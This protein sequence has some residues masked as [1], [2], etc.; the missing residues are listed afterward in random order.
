MVN[1][2]ELFAY[3]FIGN[4]EMKLVP[5]PA[6][7]SDVWLLREGDLLFARRSLTIQGAGKC[8]LIRDMTRP[9]TFESSIIRVR[10]NPDLADPTF[11]YYFFRSP[12]GR[13]AIRS[14]TEQVAVAGIRSSDLRELTLHVPLVEEQ[15]RIADV[16]ARLDRL[17]DTDHRLMRQLAEAADAVWRGAVSTTTQTKPFGG[18]ATLSAQR[19][20]PSEVAADTSYLGLEHFAEDGGGLL[21]IGQAG[22]STSLKSVFAAGDVLY[23]KL[24]PYFRKTA[25]PN[26]GGLCSTEVWVIRP[27]GGIPASFVE[28]VVSREGFTAF[29]MAGSGGTRM[30]RA[31]WAHVAR[32][33]VQVPGTAEMASAVAT[34]EVLR[35][36]Y[37]ALWDEIADAERTR[38]EL[39]GPLMNGSLVPREVAA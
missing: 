2:G 26:F 12:A 38:D 7:N 17:I 36:Q 16:L 32:M 24:R 29:A 14:I 4:Q 19:R 34:A 13:A 28:W 18:L 10:L 20:N 39:L 33:P 21:G 25:R 9:T 15:R 35:D 30:P 11:F 8:C 27:T 1:M 5:M 22:S 31:A 6:G 3:N 37:W 23:G